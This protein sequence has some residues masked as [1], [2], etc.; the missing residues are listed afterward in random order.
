M[1][2]QTYE[3]AHLREQGQDMIIVPVNSSVG[4]KSQQQ[5]NE[6]KNSLEFYKRLDT[7]NSKKLYY[8]I[9]IAIRNVQDERKEPPIYI[10]DVY[11]L[12]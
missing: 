2:T 3:I 4:C 6:I 1:S 5:Q 9:Q 10:E 12:T 11:S 7:I 8:Q